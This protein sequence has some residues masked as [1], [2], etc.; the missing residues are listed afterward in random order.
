MSLKSVGCLN[1]GI[2]WVGKFSEL[3]WATDSHLWLKICSLVQI[4]MVLPVQ[5]RIL[6][7]DEQSLSEGVN[8]LG[9]TEAARQKRKKWSP[10]RTYVTGKIDPNSK[11]RTKNFRQWLLKIVTPSLRNLNNG[12]TNFSGLHGFYFFARF[13]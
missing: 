1:L 9:N 11:S 13:N 10:A 5:G 6:N 4:F 7:K 2:M 8:G 12:M 3:I